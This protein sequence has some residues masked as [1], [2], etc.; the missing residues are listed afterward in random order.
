M[1]FPGRKATIL[2]RP[3]PRRDLLIG[4]LVA[5]LLY[6]AA[7]WASVAGGWMISQPLYDGLATLPPY[8]WVNPPQERVKNNE[9]PKTERVKVRVDK[10][11]ADPSSVATSDAQAILTFD[12]IPRGS[13]DSFT[14]VLTPVDPAKLAPVPKGGYFDGNAYRIEG[15]YDATKAPVP[16]PFTLILRYSVHARRILKLEDGTWMRQRFAHFTQA[17]QQVDVKT[18]QLGTFV[19]AGTGKRPREQNPYRGPL[20]EI[21]MMVALVVGLLA[22][23]RLRRLRA[24]RRSR[25]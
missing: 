6:I 25:R 3:G 2:K 8:R 23:P 21:G 4:G 22:V 15:T 14:V 9:V 17:N 10:G 1:K 5:A 24:A 7:A 13:S 11:V 16:G 12:N 19:V 20:I 18:E